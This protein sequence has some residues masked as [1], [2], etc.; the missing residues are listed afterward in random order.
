MDA[1]RRTG[2]C[3]ANHSSSSRRL[4][5]FFAAEVA[6]LRQQVVHGAAVTTA[7]QR[8]SPASTGKVPAPATPIGHLGIWRNS[9]MCPCH[10]MPVCPPGDTRK[11]IDTNLL[12]LVFEEMAGAAAAD[13]EGELVGEV[14]CH[15]RDPARSALQSVFDEFCQ[16]HLYKGN[17]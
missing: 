14:A 4:L 11:F 15:Y 2:A 6:H 1:L 16:N 17:A 8:G 3:M 5:I 9:L 10:A 13:E 7:A 12:S